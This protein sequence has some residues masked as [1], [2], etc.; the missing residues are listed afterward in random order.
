MLPLSILFFFVQTGAVIIGFAQDRFHVDENVGFV[1]LTVSILSGEL[2]GPVS[3]NFSVKNGAAMSTIDYINPGDITLRFDGAIVEQIVR[4]TII[5][6][7]ILEST[8]NF[9]SNLIS[10]NPSVIINP[11]TAEVFINGDND[12]MLN[13]VL[14]F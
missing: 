14:S 8:E 3:V 7:D 12:R 1:V 9:F 13:I 2:A 10:S 6:D 4:I 5:L 11:R